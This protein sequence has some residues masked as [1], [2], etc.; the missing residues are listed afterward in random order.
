VYVG[1]ACYLSSCEHDVIKIGPEF[2][3]QKSNVLCVGGSS[4]IQTLCYMTQVEVYS[5]GKTFRLLKLVFFTYKG[6]GLLQTSIYI[7]P[8]GC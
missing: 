5:D 6:A 3:E 1:R 8:R 7:L 4:K 2:L